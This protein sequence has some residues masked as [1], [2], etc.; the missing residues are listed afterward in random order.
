MKVFKIDESKTVDNYP[1]GRLQCEATFSLEFKP[2]K[3]YRKVFQTVN[4]KTGRINNPRKSTYNQSGAT[5]MVFDETTGRI[6]YKSVSFY[7]IEKLNDSLEFISK[8][9]DTYTKEEIKEIYMNLIVFLKT[10]VQAKV[11]YCGAEPKEV[12]KVIDPAMKIAISGLKSL[13]NRFL[14]ISIDIEA[15]NKTKVEGYEPFKVVSYS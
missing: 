3:G 4:P 9:F 1:Y 2:G 7:H 14:D 11:V 13:D 15:L 12:I 6:R 8:H 5:R 10:E